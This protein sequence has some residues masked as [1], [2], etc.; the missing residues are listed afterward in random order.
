MHDEVDHEGLWNCYL[1]IH[2]GVDDGIV[3][4]RG[5]CQE[6]GHG[7]GGG[8]QVAYSTGHDDDTDQCVGQPGH[9]ETSDHQSHHLGQAFLTF[10]RTLTDS[11]LGLLNNTIN[12]SV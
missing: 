3:D 10:G 2:E 4:E 1:G 11:R 8:G 6:G 12:Y 5:L 9:Q 7:S